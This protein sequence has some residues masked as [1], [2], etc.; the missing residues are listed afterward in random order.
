MHVG[1]LLQMAADGMGERVAL[2]SRTGGIT[3]AELAARA[4]RAGTVLADMPGERVAFIDLN[5]EAVPIALF[6]AALAGKPFVPINY[7]LTD[8]QLRDLVRPHG[9]GHGHRRRGD[10]RPPGP[11]RRDRAARAARSSSSCT[12]D[13]AVAEADPYGGDPDTIAVLLYTSGTTGAAEGGGAPQ[14]AT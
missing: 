4:R 1:M 12:V 13:P 10:R 11:H 14:P 7:R 6:G 8:E 5:S 9:T 3:M 2:G